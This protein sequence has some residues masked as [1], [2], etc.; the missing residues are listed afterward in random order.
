M[1]LV[2][3]VVRLNLDLASEQETTYQCSAL[4]QECINQKYRLQMQCR[5]SADAADL[6]EYGDVIFKFIF[7]TAINQTQALFVVYNRPEVTS[8]SSG[9]DVVIY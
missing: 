4:Q 8:L 2:C 6:T 7:R 1:N 9:S 3:N 5:C